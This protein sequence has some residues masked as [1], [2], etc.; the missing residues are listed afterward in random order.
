MVG[1]TN[2]ADIDGLIAVIDNPSA[3]R[4]FPSGKELI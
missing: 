3:G 1:N 2:T 4:V